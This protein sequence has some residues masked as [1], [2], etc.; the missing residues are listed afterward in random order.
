MSTAFVDTD[1]CLDLLAGREPHYR[2][3]AQLFT[4]ADQKAIAVFS[5]AQTFANLHYLL[6][7]SFSKD[8]CRR[9]LTQFKALCGVLPVGDKVIEL[10][11][12]SDFTD[13]EDAIQYFTAVE[14]GLS[15]LITRN[16]RDYRAAR[17]AVLSPES[18]LN[19]LTA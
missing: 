1:V 14:G 4:L 16:T 6:L 3:A 18:Y 13:F 12:Q 5:S 15:T 17:I 2:H 9:K 7:K 11:L 8:Q 10:A 19:T